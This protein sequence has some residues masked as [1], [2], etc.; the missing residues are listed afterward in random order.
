MKGTTKATGPALDA[1]HGVHAARVVDDRDPED[2]GRVQVE[3]PQLG[4]ED[5]GGL[6]LWARLAVPLAGPDRGTWFVPEVD[7]EVLVAFES[8]DPSRPV[9][10]GSMWSGAHRPPPEAGEGSERTLVRTRSGVTLTLDDSDG[11]E[12][13]VIETPGGRRVSLRDDDGAVLLEDGS[14]V[15]VRLAAAGLELRSPTRVEVHAS[16]V[17][18]SA[19]TL[20][21]NSG[22]S[23]FSGV[24]K[25]DTVITNSVVASSY[26]PGA[27]NVW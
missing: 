21:V 26:T 24:V 5:D 22:M 3:L 18:V 16:T 12:A 25:A 6:V 1:L 10:L 27:G 4:A 17:E 9:V 13:V 8:G 11:A 20:T 7:D 19:A 2:T 15:Q 14:G 23:T